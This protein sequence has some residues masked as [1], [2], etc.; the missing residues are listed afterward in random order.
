MVS[1]IIAKLSEMFT[2]I[3]KNNE[4]QLTNI[5]SE[6]M[7]W[8]SEDKIL[9]NETINDMLNLGMMRFNFYQILL[10]QLPNFP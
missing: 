9:L 2:K 10:L 7:N 5:Q 3:S 6:I 4:L 8:S 1:K